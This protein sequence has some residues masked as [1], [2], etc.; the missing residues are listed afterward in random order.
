MFTAKA[1]LVGITL[2]VILIIAVETIDLVERKSEN[3]E[4]RR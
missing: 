3:N 1:E 4:N 2:A